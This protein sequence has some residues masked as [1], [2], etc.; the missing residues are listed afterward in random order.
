[1]ETRE[2]SLGWGD[3]PKT[4][5]EC[6]TAPQQTRA[7]LK[8]AVPQVREWT[9]QDPCW[10]HWGKCL[11][12]HCWARRNIDIGKC[13]I[14]LQTLKGTQTL[15]V[16]VNSIKLHET[17]LNSKRKCLQGS[18]LHSLSTPLKVAMMQEN[19]CSFRLPLIHYLESK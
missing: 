15:L 16:A 2:D 19:T 3:V 4:I 6:R 1:M 7:S 8:C 5:P 14:I 11:I 18:H 10:M 17:A 12:K 13:L 9:Q